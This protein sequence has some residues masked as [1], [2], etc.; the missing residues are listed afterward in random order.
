MDAFYAIESRDVKTKFFFTGHAPNQKALDQE[1]Q[2][3]H[4]KVIKSVLFVFW[5]NF[6]SGGG[7]L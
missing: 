7:D 3:T 1:A 2:G 5:K 6:Y 4:L